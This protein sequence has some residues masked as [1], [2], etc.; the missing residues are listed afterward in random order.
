MHHEKQ[1]KLYSYTHVAVYGSCSRRKLNFT[2]V[3]INLEVL[4]SCER[5]RPAEDVCILPLREIAK[6][7]ETFFVSFIF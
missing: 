6:G 3:S 7:A 1:V 5:T 2:I 4:R